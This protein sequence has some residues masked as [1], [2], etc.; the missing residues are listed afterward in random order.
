VAQNFRHIGTKQAVSQKNNAENRESDAERAARRFEQQHD[1]HHADPHI[2]AARQALAHDDAFVIPPDIERGGG[3]GGA[4]RNI[5]ERDA[6]AQRAPLSLM[7]SRTFNERISNVRCGWRR[8]LHT[9]NKGESH[10]SRPSARVGVTRRIPPRRLC[11]PGLGR[12][13]WTR[14][15]SSDSASIWRGSVSLW[16][17]VSAK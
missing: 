10:E 11:R 7:Y 9:R 3:S 8:C 15:F 14:L 13:R 12:A 2:G 4:Q 5:E 16:R 17:T 6:A 1:H